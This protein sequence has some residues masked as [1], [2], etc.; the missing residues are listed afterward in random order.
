MIRNGDINTWIMSW[1]EAE[2]CLMMLQFLNGRGEA[3]CRTKAA[4]ALNESIVETY[5]PSSGDDVVDNVDMT[6]FR[7]EYENYESADASK[8]TITVY[9]CLIHVAGGVRRPKEEPCVV[10]VPHP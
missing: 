6:V 2:F 3:L 8:E 9:C 10:E 5:G 4:D 1:R 7:R